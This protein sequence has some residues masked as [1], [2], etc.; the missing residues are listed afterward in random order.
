MATQDQIRALLE[1]HANKDEKRFTST[2]LQLAAQAA[3]NGQSRFS[4]QLKQ[5]VD[6]MRTESAATLVGQKSEPQTS[7]VADDDF[8]GLSNLVSV[9]YPKSRLSE[10]VLSD[11]TSDA[12]E[13]LLV[14]QRQRDTLALHGL[15]P[16]LR[17]L[18][19]GPPG[20]GKTSSARVIA[21]ELNLP[22]YTVRLETVISKYMGETAARLRVIFDHATA[23]RAVYFFDEFDALA[24]RRS[25][26]HDVGEMRRVLSSFLQFLE[27]NA[28]ESVILAATNN[29]QLLDPAVFRRFDLLINYD[30]PDE[31]GIQRLIKNRIARVPLY[32]ISWKKV[33]ASAK[34]MSPAEICSAAEEAGKSMLLSDRDKVTT[35]DLLSSLEKR[36]R[37]M[38]W[39]D[40]FHEE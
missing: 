38:N 4:F 20:T 30:L 26:G 16:I 28:S 17:A 27:E 24:V 35:T 6:Q 29:P 13:Q 3:R 22:L 7:L 14:E 8:N 18:L 40:S 21:G 25:S 33:A 5:L 2:A 23:Q 32:R 37:A 19:V 1:S 12:I 36:Q 31:Q 11:D 15:R 34:G 10:L 39:Y 9:S